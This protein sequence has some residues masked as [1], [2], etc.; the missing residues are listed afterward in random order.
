MMAVN[1]GTELLIYG[2]YDGVSTQDVIWK[3]SLPDNKWTFVGRMIVPRDDLFVL[4]VGP[5]VICE[6]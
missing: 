2:G 5:D 3:Y 1:G 4:P 6:I